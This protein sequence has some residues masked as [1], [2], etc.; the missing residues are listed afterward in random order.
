MRPSDN[1]TR[2]RERSSHSIKGTVVTASR[3]WELGDRLSRALGQC[4]DTPD[5]EKWSGLG[6]SNPHG[7]RVRHYKIK[8]LVRWRLPSVISGVNFRGMWGHVGLRRDT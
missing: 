1:E 2:L 5:S 6:E 8:G 7:R 4:R 3:L